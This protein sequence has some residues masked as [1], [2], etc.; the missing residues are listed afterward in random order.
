MKKIKEKYF[1]KFNVESIHDLGL[2]DFLAY[3]S[4]I[5]KWRG[6]IK[7]RKVKKNSVK[8]WGWN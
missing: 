3:R 6:K 1:A 8:N 4:E 7:N 5:A 2:K